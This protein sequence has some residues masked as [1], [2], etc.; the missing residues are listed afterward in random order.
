MRS[1]VATTQ[2]RC[3]GRGIIMESPAKF[4]DPAKNLLIVANIANFALGNIRTHRHFAIMVI[5][6]LLKHHVVPSADKL[7]LEVAERERNTVTFDTL[8]PA[9]HQH[10]FEGFFYYEVCNVV[11]FIFVTVHRA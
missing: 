2:I 11:G 3:K 5:R 4:A 1:D 7:P 10:D 8:N 6:K 9:D